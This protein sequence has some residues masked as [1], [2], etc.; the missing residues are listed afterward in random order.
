MHVA[1][2]Y[3]FLAAS[4]ALAASRPTV[5]VVLEFEKA[6][7]PAVIAEMEREA[8]QLFAELGIRVDFKLRDELGEYPQFERLVNVRFNGDCKVDKTP[9]ASAPRGALAFT[10]VVDGVVLPFSEVGCGRVREFVRA[11]L[12]SFE[13]DADLVFGRALGRVVAHELYHMVARTRKHG[14]GIAQRALTAF[15]L[16]SP[17]RGFI[18]AGAF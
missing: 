1:R 9:Q 11:S 3:A 8:T 10:H 13:S 4:T 12:R 15:E 2:L 6:A 7:A 16:I 5:T 17:A 14:K 18:S